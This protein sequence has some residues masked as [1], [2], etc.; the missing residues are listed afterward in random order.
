MCSLATQGGVQCDGVTVSGLNG[1]TALAVGF[2]HACAVVAGGA[3]ACWGDN[4]QGQLG[5]GAEVQHSSQPVL[6]SG[7]S[8]ATAIAAGGYFT[9]ALGAG[10]KITCWGDNLA[11]QLGAATAQISPTPVEVSGIANASA[12]ATGSFHACAIVDGSVLCWGSDIASGELS[13]SSVP[14][15]VLGGQGATSIAA[16]SEHACAVVDTGAVKCWG[17]NLHG[18]LGTG[19][20]GGSSSPVTVV[21]WP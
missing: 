17:S 13:P 12:I 14:R 19:T 10:G 4:D 16:G 8:G 20:V 7:V 9:C 2:R 6:V 15:I 3:V 21:G 18:Q 1:A 11:G 5:K